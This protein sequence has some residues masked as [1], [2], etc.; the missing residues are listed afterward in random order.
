MSAAIALGIWLLMVAYDAVPPAWSF[1]WWCAVLGIG[2]LSGAVG[3]LAKRV[4]A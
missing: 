3:V 2:I 4:S 1:E